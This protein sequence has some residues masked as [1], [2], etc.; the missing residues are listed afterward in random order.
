MY[1]FNNNIGTPHN[2]ATTTTTTIAYTILAVDLLARFA[3]AIEGCTDY[4]THFVY[5]GECGGRWLLS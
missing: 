2:S 1:N 3:A 5:L 4:V